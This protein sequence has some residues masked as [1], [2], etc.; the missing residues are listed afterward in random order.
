MK[1]NEKEKIEK[2]F[3]LS[4]FLS[5]YIPSKIYA[6]NFFETYDIYNLS[7]TVFTLC[8]GHSFCVRIINQ[9]LINSVP[10]T[11]SPRPPRYISLSDL[12]FLPHI[13]Y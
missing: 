7:V 5:I 8:S 13:E 1:K 12:I 2:R 4:I 11:P 10:W 3:F 9:R 6:F